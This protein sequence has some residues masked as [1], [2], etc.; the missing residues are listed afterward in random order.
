MFFIEN[1]NT[2]KILFVVSTS[3]SASVIASD[4][5][6]SIKFDITVNW[7]VIILVASLSNLQ[8]LIRVYETS[9]LAEDDADT[10]KKFL[11]SQL[12]TLVY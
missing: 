2:T 8:K 11:V 3:T 4:Q 5:F 12:N 10:A 6:S 9:S 1:F 7:D